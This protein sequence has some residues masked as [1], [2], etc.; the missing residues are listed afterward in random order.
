MKKQ[1]YSIVNSSCMHYLM[2]I[3]IV[4]TPTAYSIVIA[5]L[6]LVAV[7]GLVQSLVI[8]KPALFPS[9][10]PIIYKHQCVKKFSHT[11]FSLVKYNLQLL[12][13]I[14]HALIPPERIRHIHKFS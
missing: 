14:L 4:S 2:L 7:M 10:A 1:S 9:L 8:N 11:I 5:L 12:V 3:L 6:S 13:L